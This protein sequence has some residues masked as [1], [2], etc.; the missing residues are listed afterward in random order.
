MKNKEKYLIEARIDAYRRGELSDEQIDKLW[1]EL[2][3]FPENLDYL[4]NSV[5]LEKL[6]A[7]QIDSDFANTAPRDRSQKGK[8]VLYN[9]SAT[10]GKVAAT[11]L[12]IAGILSVVYL[13]GSDYIFEPQPMNEIELDTYRSS[14]IPSAEFDRQ[15]QEAI[16]LASL[17]E[18]DEALLK[19]K[20]VKQN[21]LTNEQSISLKINKGS[22]HYNRGDYPEALDVFHSILDKDYDLHILTREKVHWFLGNTYLQLDQEETAQHHIKK[23]YELNGAYRRLAERYMNN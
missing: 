19:L 8:A 2:I 10:W 1:E 17:E 12:V 16:N 4:K 23:T 13:F 11:L 9:L 22:I 3:E 21:D 7:E 6:A 14:T 20:K 5:N 15:I 18:Y